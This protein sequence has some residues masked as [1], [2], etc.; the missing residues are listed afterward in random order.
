MQRRITVALGLVGALAGIFALIHLMSGESPQAR[1]AETAEPHHLFAS[2]PKNPEYEAQRQHGTLKGRVINGVSERP[3][4]KA[5]VIALRPH[6]QKDEDDEVP[7]WGQL[8]E[9]KVVHTDADGQFE[10]ADLPPDY[11]NLWVEKA[12]YSWTTVPRA[13]FKETHTIKLYPACS[14]EGRVVYPDETPA[15]GV[16]L[17]YT[18]QGT[19]S[20]VFGRY[21]LKAYYD[22]TDSNGYFK[23]TD[24]PPGKFTV[25]VYPE[26]HLPAPWTTEPPLKPGENRNLGTHVLDG[27]F[28]MT[29]YVKYHGTDEPVPGIEVTVRPVT[30]P[31]PRTKTGRRRH[32]NAEGKAVFSGLGGQVSPEPTF[33]VV[34]NVPGV[35]AVQPNEARLFKPDETLT[36]WLRKAAKITGKVVRPDGQ[37]LKHFFIALEPVGFITRQLQQFFSNGEFLLYQVPEGEYFVHVRSGAYI[38][39]AVK[40][41]AVAGETAS[42]SR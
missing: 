22:Q 2:P 39:Q 13:K 17:E 28:G 1:P 19:H 21:R 18:P 40:V 24:L 25:E 42:T 34:A 32:T 11:W 31:M 30:D 29:V 38:D 7:M 37:P 27:G 14:I 23:Y 15:A 41:T 26:D 16:R 33:Q 5:K 12:G 20:E 35:G 4:A 9:E 10:V 3:I 6:L 8:L 36:I